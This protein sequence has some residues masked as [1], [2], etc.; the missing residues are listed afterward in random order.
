M[1]AHVINKLCNNVNDNRFTL[2]GKIIKCEIG[3]LIIKPVEMEVT[4]T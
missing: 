2:S 4:L 3:M 1:H